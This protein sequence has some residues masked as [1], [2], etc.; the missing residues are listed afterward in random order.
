M[1]KRIKEDILSA[2]EIICP[3]LRGIGYILDFVAVVLV[4]GIIGGIECSTLSLYRAFE[5]LGV[6]FAFVLLGVVIQK[7][8]YAIEYR[9]SDY[10]EE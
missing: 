8:T 5:L 9:N 7:F 10:T 1:K 4:F 6:C 2:I 3:F